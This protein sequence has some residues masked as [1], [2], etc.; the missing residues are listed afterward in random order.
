MKSTQPCQ[1]CIPWVGEPS[2][3]SFVQFSPHLFFT[4]ITK[5]CLAL[6]VYSDCWAS[7]PQDADSVHSASALLRLFPGTPSCCRLAHLVLRLLLSR[8]L[9]PESPA[10]CSVSGGGLQHRGAH[11]ACCSERAGSGHN[12]GLLPSWGSVSLLFTE[13]L[14]CYFNCRLCALLQDFSTYNIKTQ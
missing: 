10:F 13:S 5:N 7:C 8:S 4:V 9:L 1:A 6:S 2:L 3:R 14:Y 12:L 11:T